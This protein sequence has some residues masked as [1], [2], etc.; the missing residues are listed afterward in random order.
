MTTSM[1]EDPLNYFQQ[2]LAPRAELIR[3]L[4]NEAQAE[5]IPIVGPVVAQLL[6]ILV[7]LQHAEIVVELGTATGYS[8][9][10]L[11]NACLQT[12]GR[13]ISY[14]T[15]PELAARAWKNI[16]EAGL[17]G[18]V[19]IRSENALSGMAN[20]NDPV[21]MIFMDIEKE[22]YIRALPECGRLLKAG[23]L[24]FADNTGFRDAHSFNE[25]IH[26]DPTWDVVNLWSYLP[27]HSPNHDGICMALKR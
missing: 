25:A 4:E 9:I 18:V 20:F 5:Q 21:D 10:F 2:W 27:G 13:V 26:L 15:N 17:E 23:G 24:L 1:V 3:R 19:E 8:T 16:Q 6:S 11:A 7:Q 22:D 14:E 12:K